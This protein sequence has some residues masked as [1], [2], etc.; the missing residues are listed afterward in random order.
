VNFGSPDFWAYV[1]VTA[2]IYTIFGLGLQ[3]QLG[4]AGLLNF[5]YVAF[6]AVS[7]YTMAILTVREGLPLWAASLCAIAAAAIF[8][9]AVGLACLRLRAD[10]FA[11]TTFALAEIVRYV[12][13]NATSLTGGSQGTIALLGP[14]RA[15]TYN[16]SWT[17]FQADVQRW[18]SHLT[19][20]AFSLTATMLVIV[21]LV[22][23]LL[24]VLL[25]FCV[26]QPWGRVLRS[27]REDEDAAAALGK[28]VFSYKLQALAVGAAVAGIAGLLYAFQFGF[29]GPSDFDPLTTL[30]AFMVVIL[31]GNARN[32][33]VPVGAFIYGVLYAATRFLDFAPFSYVG[34]AER[35]YL[36]LIVVGAVLIGLMAFRPQGL[37]GKRAELVLE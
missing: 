30:I 35:A 15:A 11:I 22:A 29:F 17:S 3:I 10:Y 24:I 2:G 5:G 13:L 37:F 19:G 28:N 31:G 26:H 32:W 34:T 16:T 27:I 9:V 7:A 21:W 23:L 12:A 36:R 25:Q 33:G 4:F 20:T 18:L 14:Q 1:S 6:M 8:S